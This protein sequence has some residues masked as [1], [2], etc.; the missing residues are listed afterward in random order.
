ML[1]RVMIDLLS[2]RSNW[3]MF[4]G[5]TS[6]REGIRWIRLASFGGILVLLTLLPGWAVAS[7]TESLDFGRGRVTIVTAA[8]CRQLAVEIA[9]DQGQRSRGLMGRESLAEEVGMLFL[10]PERQPPEAG[11]WMYRTLIPLDIAFVDDG[12]AIVATQT[13]PPCPDPD[14]AGCH[15]YRPGVAYRAA[16]EVNSGYFAR[17]G[18]GPGDRLFWSEKQED[19]RSSAL[20][21]N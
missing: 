17:H 18:I 7:G 19:G 12:G 6:I 4:A 13:M 16:L 1:Q 10:Y 2:E 15:I 3:E 21:G 9:A 11:F 5:H 14:P 8:G 20:C